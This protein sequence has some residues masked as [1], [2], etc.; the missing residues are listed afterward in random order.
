MID[1]V[2]RAMGLALD[3]LDVGFCA[4]DSQDR[5]VAWNVT[6][7]ELFPEHDG[8]VRVGEHYAENLRRFYAGRLNEDERHD[9]DRYVQE[10]LLRHRRQQRPYEFDHADYRLRVSS[11]ELGPFGRVRI[12][13]KVATLPARVVHPGSSTRRL[14]ET[15][16]TAVLERF[17]DGVLIVDV[18]NQAMWANDAFLQLYGLRSLDAVIGRTFEQLYS[19]TWAGLREERL[20]PMLFSLR[21]GQRYPGMPFELSLPGDRC[22]RVVA[23]TGEVDGRGYFVHVDVTDSK[24][25][26]AALAKA[27]SSYRLLAEHS[28]DIIIAMQGGLI[29]YASPAIT[30]LLGWDPREVQGQHLVRLC[31][32][33]DVPAVTSALKSLQHQ[34]EVDHRA[35]AMHKNGSHVWVEARA[36]RTKSDAH[37]RPSMLVLNLRSIMARKATEEEQERTAQ[38]MA[39]LVTTDALTGLANRRKLEQALAAEWRRAQREGGALSVLVLDIDHFKTLNDTYGHPFGDAVLRSFGPMLDSFTHRAG[40]LAA[41]LGGEEFVLLLPLT[42]ER[43]ALAVAEKL[44][45]AVEQARFG[46]TR[47]VAITVSIGVATSDGHAFKGAGAMVAAADEALY[48]AKRGGRNRVVAAG[49]EPPKQTVASSWLR[50]Q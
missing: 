13:R 5:A 3:G 15:N 47:E 43:Q 38:R 46:G 28:S 26:Q 12:W 1:A 41:R 48:A 49:R 30:P 40:D 14:A 36:T 44:R 22:V 35:R 20:E 27:E 34:P 32:P 21:E 17:T 42:D 4:F 10:G 29:S 8:H 16:A 6:F 24:R 9:I 25:Q 45:S 33:D 18:A 50:I 31:H 39:A 11:V 37:G 19:T 2:L 23:Q 7:L